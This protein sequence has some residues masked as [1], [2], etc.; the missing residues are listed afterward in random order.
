MPKD[1]KPSRRRKPAAAKIEQPA[2]ESEPVAQPSAEVHPA[3]RPE[4]VIRER[5]IATT[6]PIVARVADVIRTVAVALIDI[7]DAA[8]ESLTRQIER[9]T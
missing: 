3:P 4:V 1:K 7:A 8:A 9:R 5:P 2:I 6:P